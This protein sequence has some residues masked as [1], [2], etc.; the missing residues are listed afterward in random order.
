MREVASYLKEEGD[1]LGQQ[2]FLKRRNRIE[3]VAVESR[4]T[5]SLQI[6]LE[7]DLKSED[8]VPTGQ[9]VTIA[10][11]LREVRMGQGRG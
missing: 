2:M 4:R 11:T 9:V 8:T 6:T 3:E 1:S 10:E 7:K 5:E